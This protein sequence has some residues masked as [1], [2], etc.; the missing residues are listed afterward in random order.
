[1]IYLGAI[2][3]SKKKKG[4]K[5]YRIIEDERHMEQRSASNKY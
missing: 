1:V 2:F 4:D 3:A 5:N